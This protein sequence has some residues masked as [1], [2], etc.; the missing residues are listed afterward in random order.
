MTFELDKIF[1][2]QATQEEVRAPH[3]AAGRSGFPWISP[4]CSS[5]LQVFQEVQSLVTSCIDGFNVC[6]FAYGQTGSGKTYTMEVWRANK[7]PLNIEASVR[8][9]VNSAPFCFAGRG[10]RPRDQPAS[11]PPAV[12]RGDGESAGLGLQD[13]SEP[14]GDLQRD[15]AV[16]HLMT[17]CGRS[18]RERG[19]LKEKENV[20][21]MESQLLSL[22]ENHQAVILAAVLAA[23]LVVVLAVVLTVVLAFCPRSDLLRENPTDK[24]DIKMNPDGSGQLY[25]PGLTERTVQSPED[26]NR[27]RTSCLMVLDS[28]PP[29]NRQSQPVTSV[30]P[31]VCAGVRAGSRQQSDGVHQPERA[32][33]ALP[34]A[35]HHHRVGIQRRHRNPDSGFVRLS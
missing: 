29:Q 33:L 31:S 32:Q 24:L 13:H 10:R 22:S 25:V 26:I 14:G 12:R 3:A 20:V 21:F 27:V 16:R 34:R 17:S 30:R 4:V 18:Q 9:P 6:I 5:L 23:V 15:A 11:A 1:P 7:H 8:G 2:P 35:A 28:D 19:V